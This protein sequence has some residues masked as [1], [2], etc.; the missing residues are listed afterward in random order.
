MKLLKIFLA[1]ISSIMYLRTTLN[2]PQYSFKCSPRG[3]RCFEE[4]QS[5]PFVCFRLWFLLWY[6]QYKI[7]KSSIDDILVIRLIL[8]QTK[9]F[10]SG[11]QWSTKNGSATAWSGVSQSALSW[12]IKKISYC[13]YD[14]LCDWLIDI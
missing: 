5:V 11:P 7:V 6:N 9:A 4:T 12:K 2:L 14:L 1:F 8:Y 10:M 3:W 13:L